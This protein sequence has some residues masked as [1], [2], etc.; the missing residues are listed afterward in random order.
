MYTFIVINRKSGA[1]SKVFKD[2]YDA[3]F[4]IQAHQQGLYA[5]VTVGIDENHNVFQCDCCEY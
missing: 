1:V 4:Y 3:S 5:I 2:Y